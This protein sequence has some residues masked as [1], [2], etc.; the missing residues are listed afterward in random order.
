[1]TKKDRFLSSRTRRANK[2]VRKFWTENVEKYFTADSVALDNAA[3]FVAH[4]L[5][6]GM[7]CSECKSVWP[8]DTYEGSDE[9]VFK[10]LF[11]RHVVEE[12]NSTC[13]WQGRDL[14]ITVNPVGDIIAAHITVQN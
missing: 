11:N 13:W 4:S 8:S 6:P 5:L 7:E 3:S 1:M 9:H 10:L 12:V 14:V 2:L